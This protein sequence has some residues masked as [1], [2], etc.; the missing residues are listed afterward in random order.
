MEARACDAAAP[1][2]WESGRDEGDSHVG[3]QIIRAGNLRV[4]TRAVSARSGASRVGAQDTAVSRVVVRVSRVLRVVWHT[5]CLALEEPSPWRDCML[6]AWH[7]ETATC[8]PVAERRVLGCRFPMWRGL[9]EFSAPSSLDGLKDGWAAGGSRG[10]FPRQCWQPRSRACCFAECAVTTL[11]GRPECCFET[12]TAVRIP[13]AGSAECSSGCLM[14][15]DR[16]RLTVV[17][18][19][20]AGLLEHVPAEV[21]RISRFADVHVVFEV[22]PRAWKS[23]P[24]DLPSIDWSPGVYDA[25]AYLRRVLPEGVWHRVSSCAGLW[26]AVYPSMIRPRTVPVLWA[27]AQKVKRIDPDIMHFDG[28][29]LRGALWIRLVHAPYVVAV[30]EP[31][32]PLG[33][34]LPQLALAQRM[35]VP[36]ADRLVVHS[37]ACRSELSERWGIASESMTLCPL[38]PNDVFHAWSGDQPEVNDGRH[39]R[40]VLWG[41]LGA[42][43]GIDTYLEAARIA[44]ASLLGVTFVLAGQCIPGYA[45][46]ALPELA[47]GCRFE[48]LEKWL[49]NRELCELVQSVDVVALPYTDAMQSGVVLTAFAF[50]KPVVASAAGGILEQVEPGHTGELFAPGDADAMA[51]T[52]VGLLGDAGRLSRM[53]AE[54]LSRW[55]PDAKW[56]AFGEGVRDAYSHVVGSLS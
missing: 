44:S 56:N 1:F 29:S 17:F 27:I 2:W 8:T 40:V 46:P 30:H 39:L 13:A 36:R 7:H 9:V 31:R 23:N 14:R 55:D 22:T 45:L 18:H 43:K 16:S 20:L 10:A 53:K 48:V 28:E 49:G 15:P 52:L 34:R 32:V 11:A 25:R 4:D 12:D 24:L 3:L 50:G 42:R 33:D 35:L 37:A 54:I 47:N 5:I 6:G 38:G 19:A 41:R 21:E 51:K 26:Y